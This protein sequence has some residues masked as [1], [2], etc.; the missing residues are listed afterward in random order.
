ML[1]SNAVHWYEGMFLSPHHFQAF[2]Q[3]QFQQN[4][5]GDIWIQ[6]HHWGLRS[7]DLDLDALT[8][9]RLVVRSLEAR[10]RDG[11]SIAI[12][13]DGQL[14]IL[15]L[16]HAMAD[17]Q[18]L[19]IYL[20]VPLLVSGQSNVADTPT[21]TARYLVENLEIEDQNS[22]SNQQTIQIRRLNLRLLH[23]GDNHAGYET[24]PIARIRRS[25]RGEA[26]PQLDETYIPP[27]L[28]CDAW[29]PLQAKLLQR[30]YDRLG[31]KLDLLASQIVSRKISF[32]S[33]GQ[34]DQQLLEQLRAINECY[35]TIQ[36]VAFTPGTHPSVAFHELA[37]TIGKLA[38]FGAMRRP[39]EMPAY[40]HDDLAGCFWRQKQYIDAL[41]DAVVEP[42]YRERHFEGAGL[43]MQVDL[44]PSWLEGSNK[45]FVG[46]ESSL[47]P[48]QI[49]RLLTRGLDMKIGSSDKVVELYRLG[50]AGLKFNYA[51]HPP[52]ALPALP[53]VSY[54]EIDRESQPTQWEQVKHSL[55]LAI[56]LN[57]NL[58]VSDIEGQRRLTIRVDGQSTTLQFTLYVVPNEPGV[59]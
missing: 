29:Q 23:D 40:D 10:L 31:R 19:T 20:A 24:L 46:V 25:D 26:V 32:D 22:G 15:D 35:P 56:R 1:S 36:L 17:R 42:D 18:N 27:L 55:T 59:A 6:R 30:I 37:R 28:S 38:V 13:S 2:E 49:D 4:H 52:R 39:P 33:R 11:S 44:E 54:F 58:I 51:S 48:Q 9:S 47:P 50:Q 53:G 57:E 7:I 41:L 45:L 12:P 43:R 8:N 21:S 5:R 3:H 16:R 14:P 34:G